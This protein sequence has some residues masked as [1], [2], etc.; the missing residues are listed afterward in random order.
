MHLEST[1]GRIIRLDA[2]VELSPGMFLQY[3]TMEAKKF[4]K[5]ST[6]QT[7]V[8]KES[9]NHCCGDKTFFDAYEDLPSFH[10]EFF[11]CFKEEEFENNEQHPS[12]NLL[13]LDSAHRARIAH[14]S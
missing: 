3:L 5:E 2:V 6:T 9:E 4:W 13:N 7:K 14:A 10:E 11:D 12:R 8:T 1:Y